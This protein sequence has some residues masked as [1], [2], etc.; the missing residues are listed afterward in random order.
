MITF[1]KNLPK[2]IYHLI[3]TKECCEAFIETI[4]NVK[5]SIET[6]WCI[7][8]S[9][10]GVKHTLEEFVRYVE[11]SW[12][13]Y[14]DTFVLYS[15]YIEQKKIKVNVFDNASDYLETR[16][17]LSSTQR[18]KLFEMEQLSKNVSQYLS[19]HHEII[20][21]HNKK[22]RKLTSEYE[23]KIKELYDNERLQ[24]QSVLDRLNEEMKRSKAK[25]EN[26]Q[27]LTSK[28]SNDLFKCTKQ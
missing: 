14:F 6:R 15:K 28:Y 16:K 12:K 3:A 22:K 1:V 20:T 9:L 2:K 19:K 21:I 8:D 5:M 4:P 27:S 23:A 18:R 17:S 13:T 24:E 11:E 25:I 26:L 10:S 7:T